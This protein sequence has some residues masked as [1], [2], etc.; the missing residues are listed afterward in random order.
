MQKLALFKLVKSK[1]HEFLDFCGFFDSQEEIVLYL[2]EIQK[3]IEQKFQHQL[4]GEY[5]VLP[6]FYYNIKRKDIST[7]NNYKQ[8]S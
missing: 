1:K 7:P 3:M 4:E 8:T 2:E 5:V 6:S